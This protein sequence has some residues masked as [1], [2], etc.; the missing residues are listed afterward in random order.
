M[1]KGLLPLG[2]KSG[3]F[4]SVDDGVTNIEFELFQQ[5][6]MLLTSCVS[7]IIF[8]KHT[9]KNMRAFLLKAVRCDDI[10]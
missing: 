3:Q 8:S 4:N 7:M 6:V 10:Y 1:Q 2:V 9:V 5:S